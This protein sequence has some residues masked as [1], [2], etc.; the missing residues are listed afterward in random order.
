MRKKSGV[1]GFFDDGLTY[2]F[3]DSTGLKDIRPRHIHFEVKT[4]TADDYETCDVR[5]YSV[6][7]VTLDEE[8]VKEQVEEDA[9]AEDTSVEEVVEEEAEQEVITKAPEGPNE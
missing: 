2:L 6:E 3:K 8:E 4:S 9:E 1:E 5:F 7:D